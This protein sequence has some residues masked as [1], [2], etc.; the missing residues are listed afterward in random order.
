MKS[1]ASS[2]QTGT[3]VLRPRIRTQV[4]TREIEELDGKQSDDI[5]EVEEILAHEKKDGKL[6]FLVKWKNF[7]HEENSWEPEKHFETIGEDILNEYSKTRAAKPKAPGKSRRVV[8][9]RQRRPTGN[10]T[11]DMKCKTWRT[12]AE[13][14]I[15]LSELCA[16]RAINGCDKNFDGRLE[17]YVTWDNGK[18]TWHDKETIY[19]MCPQMV[20]LDYYEKKARIYIKEE[21]PMGDSLK[22]WSLSVRSW[23]TKIESIDRLEKDFAGCL[24]FR[25]AWN[26]GKHTWHDKETIYQ[27][28][29]QMALQ[30]YE[31]LVVGT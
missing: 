17:F 14:Q 13:K 6:K 1:A 27:M 29:P 23:E 31:K 3:N 8:K 2:S 15:S 9:S 12:A 19:Q 18:Q 20:I 10:G 5:F 11:S 28:C 24:K 21:Q 7:G 22:T 25:V 30:F 26:N 4:S 16:V